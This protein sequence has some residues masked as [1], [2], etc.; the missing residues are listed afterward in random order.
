VSDNSFEAPCYVAED[1]PVLLGEYC[2]NVRKMNNSV[3]FVNPREEA[4]AK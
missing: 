3:T 2:S 4:W 1:K